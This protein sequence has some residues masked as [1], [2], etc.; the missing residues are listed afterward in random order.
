MVM[1]VSEGLKGWSE[2][3]SAGPT[4]GVHSLLTAA[5]PA[6]A[7][8]LA[9]P[10]QL[11]WLKKTLGELGLPTDFLAGADRLAERAAELRT[12]AWKAQQEAGARRGKVTGRVAD[13]QLSVA[14]AAAEWTAEA[15]WLDV[16]PNQTRPVA[17][18]LAE[19]GARQVESGIL[20][21]ILGHAERLFDM[22]QR[23]AAEVVAEVEALPSMPR[24]FWL[25]SDPAGELATRREHHASW[26]VLLAAWN[27]FSSCHEV[28]N[29]TQDHI[30]AGF[31]NFPPGCTRTAMWLKGWRSSMDDITFGRLK[32]PLKLRYAIE[33]GWG[34]GLW[35]PSDVEEPRPAD[36]SFS[37]R[38]RN[39]GVAVGING[40]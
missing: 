18:E 4:M 11:L 9:P 12:E 8:N 10:S 32:R 37:G 22:V 13:G 39:L 6:S 26:G 5:M 27:D 24:N 33:H 28:A 40:G 2:G 34:P 25:T 21:Q 29:L 20:W 14:D 36:R 15:V 17:L 1:T 3:P 35:R 19:R 38:L 31:A 30:G 7:A 23:R 16:Q